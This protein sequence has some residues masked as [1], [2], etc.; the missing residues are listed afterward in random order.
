MSDPPQ[1]S[2]RE[3]LEIALICALPLEYNAVSLLFDRFWDDDGGHYGR[4]AGDPNTYTTG[5]IGKY[6]VVLTLL[7]QIGKV[8]AASAAAN[9]R[10]SYTGLKPALLVGICGGVPNGEGEG[11]EILLGDVVIS[12][13]IV[14]YYFGRRYPNVFM[15]RDTVGDSLGRANKDIRGLLATLDTERGLERLQQRT[16]HHLKILQANAGHQKRRV[17]YNYP[18][19]TEDRL[20]EPSYRH[21]HHDTPMCICKDCNEK[22]DPVCEGSLSSPC[23]DLQCNE[24]HLVPRERL[25]VKRQ[26]EWAGDSSAQDPAIHIG[27]IASSD[28]VMKSGEDRD[29]IAKE[30]GVI[31]FEIE[32]AGVWD[33]VP[34]VVV[35]GVCDYADCHKNKRWQNFAAA[36]AAAAM[37]ALLERLIQTDK[38]PYAAGKS[39]RDVVYGDNSAPNDHPLLL[40]NLLRLLPS[41]PQATFDASGRDDSVCLPN[42]R[43]D[44]LQRIRKWAN[45]DDN[46]SFIFWLSGWAGTGKSTIAR[47]V[48]YEYHYK[49]CLAASFFFSRGKEDVSHAGRFVATIALQLAANFPVLRDLIYQAATNI[50]SKTQKE[51]W[52]LV[53]QEPLSKLGNTSLRLPLILVIDALDECDDENDIKRILGLLF[54]LKGSILFDC[55]RPETPIRLK[56]DSLPKIFHQDLILHEIPRKSVDS[57][58]SVFFQQKFQEIRD[59]SDEGLSDDWPGRQHLDRLVSSAHSL[60]IYA[61]TVCRFIENGMQ[62]FPAD[63][64]LRLILPDESSTNPSTQR[65]R[66]VI[67]YESP[68]KVLDTMYIQVLEYSFRNSRHENDRE[69]L[70]AICREILGAIIILSDPL[71]PIA[72]ARLLNMDYEIVKKRLNNL[73]ERCRAQQFWVDEKRAH[74]TLAESC[75]RLMSASLKQDICGQDA[76]GVLATELERGRVDRYLSPEL[77]YACI[78]WIQHLQKSSVQL[79]DNDQVHQFLKEHLLHWLE[80][81]SWMRK[82]SEGIHAITYLQSIALISDCPNLYAFIC[83][84]KRF[85]LYVLPAIEQAPL[86]IYCSALVFAP[87]TSVVKKRFKDKVPKWIRRFPVVE[88]DWN[89]LLQTLEGHS[90]PVTAVSFSPDSK[91]LASASRDKTVKVWDAGTGVV[92]QTLVGHSDWVTAA[93]FSPSGRVLASSSVDRTIKLW[94]TDTGTVLQSLEGHSRSVAAVAFSPDGKVLASASG[95]RTVKVWDA[96]TG[97]VLQTLEGHLNWVQAITFS[98]NSKLLASAS[99]DKTVRLWD[100]GTGAVLQTLEGHSCSVAFSPDGEVLASASGGRTVELRDAHTGAVLQTLEDRSGSVM[101]IAFSPDGKV[102][103]SACDKLRLN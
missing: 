58:I 96:R 97:V 70:T 31:A 38:L 81:M 76:P 1:P 88:K 5:R 32:G 42:T 34:C 37:K 20:F 87:A 46:A 48:A 41:A 13:T 65:S 52:K 51:Q 62:D 69:Q 85:A 86:Q 66:T 40:E 53:V 26:L 4:A 14:Q 59:Q 44:V 27:R 11:D 22:S 45:S 23:A 71:S 95:D 21:K 19:T 55:D 67:T 25:N 18:G 99:G 84:V 24:M 17:K 36:S 80:A 90:G 10:S 103:A 94:D 6:N 29:N 89:A 7:P 35:K 54:E 77:Q 50:T 68:M 92:L 9:V 2:Y 74:F 63:N 98:P 100:A 33:E 16:A 93:T 3:E 61:A 72:V 49:K 28:T 102:L 73:R 56:F 79:C 91:V 39:R 8:S 64:L 83:D 57:D 78:H 101:A 12:K 43:I 82:I 30:N 47:T 60:F 75:L 15:R